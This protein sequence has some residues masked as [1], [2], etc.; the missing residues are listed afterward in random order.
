[1]GEEGRRDKVDKVEFFKHS[2][3]TTHH[4][5][6]AKRRATANT[7]QHRLNAALPLT[8]LSTLLNA[9]LP[10]PLTALT[11]HHSLLSSDSLR[12]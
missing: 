1:M 4:S 9:P 10:L 3:V 2:A 8:L 7:T 12:R 6:P 5:P 11:T